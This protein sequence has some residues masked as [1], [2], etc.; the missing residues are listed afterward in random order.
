MTK[1][2]KPGT[3]KTGGRAKGTPNTV[4]SDLRTFYASLIDENRNEIVKRLK[5]LDDVSFF[6]AIDRLNRYVLP[7][8][9]SVSG[10]INIKN[11]LESLSNEQLEK[12]VAEILQHEE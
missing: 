5:R 10:E 3:P 2:R 8:L 6:Q 7:Q 11:Q 12:L 9:S 1:G 4:T